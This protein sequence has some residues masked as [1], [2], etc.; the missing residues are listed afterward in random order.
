MAITLRDNRFL[1]LLY[2]ELVHD[3]VSVEKELSQTRK[4]G[5]WILN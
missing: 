1:M 2:D 3:N 5:R 4:T